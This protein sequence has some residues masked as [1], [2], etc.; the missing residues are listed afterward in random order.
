MLMWT[1]RRQGNNLKIRINKKGPHACALYLR[2]SRPQEWGLNF[3]HSLHLKVNA[4]LP[5]T[6]EGLFNLSTVTFHKDFWPIYRNPGI[7]W[8]G[9]QR[10]PI[11]SQP[12]P[13]T[14]AHTHT[15]TH[16]HRS[17]RRREKGNR[18]QK[19]KLSWRKI[20]RSV[21]QVLWRPAFVTLPRY[22]Y[23]PGL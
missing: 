4:D 7:F 15:H 6:S 21:K 23:S 3:N 11:N 12:H 13:Y 20:T 10:R 19:L 8:R 17:F 22:K 16:T 18:K 14:P 1:F 5:G 2:I 9:D